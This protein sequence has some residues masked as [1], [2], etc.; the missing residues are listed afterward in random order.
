MVY[1]HHIILTHSPLPDVRVAP[2]SWRWWIVPQPM[3]L[4]T[5]DHTLCVRAPGTVA[6][7]KFNYTVT[8]YKRAVWVS[9]LSQEIVFPI[10]LWTWN[11]HKSWNNNTMNLYTHQLELWII[12]ILPYRLSAPLP[13]SFSPLHIHTYMFSNHVQVQISCYFTCKYFIMHH[14]RE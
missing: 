7:I 6:G 5:S 14:L 9:F 1:I 10:A 4:L 11:I 13:L 2:A 8:V 3:M 12:N